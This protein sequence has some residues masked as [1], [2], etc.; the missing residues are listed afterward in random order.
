MINSAKVLED[1][2]AVMIIVE[3]VPRDTALISGNLEYRFWGL[4]LAEVDG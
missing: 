3:K 2:G 4:E 1:S